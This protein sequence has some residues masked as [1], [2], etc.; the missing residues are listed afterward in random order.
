MAP[1]VEVTALKAL[2][3]RRAWEECVTNKRKALVFIPSYQQPG[4]LKSC[5]NSVLESL[6]AQI[7]I[8]D[9][10]NDSSIVNCIDEIRQTWR[11]NMVD[12]KERIDA[13]RRTTHISGWNRYK[14]ILSTMASTNAGYINFR[15]HDDQLIPRLSQSINDDFTGE[16]AHALVI[17]PIMAPA[18][19]IGRLQLLRY[20]CPPP[21]LRLLINHLPKQL[22]L[23][24]NYIGPT[25]CVWVRQ[26]VA[27]RTPT[28]DEELCWLV[29]VDWYYGLISACDRS[30]VHVSQNAFNRSLCHSKSITNQLSAQISEIQKE[31]RKLIARKVPL[32]P[33]L[34]LMAALLRP[35]NRLL[36]WAWL[37]AEVEHAS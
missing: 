7:V 22:I 8:L 14:E 15:H 26:D 24:F 27:V 37:K 3:T 13:Q 28:F 33:W 2:H 23:L 5:I 29:D 6:E 34:F 16:A 36:S 25:A 20:H 31:E 18:F 19:K 10:S 4:L 35:V 12:Y 32:S 17:H 21:L 9:D 30:E 1:S 11:T